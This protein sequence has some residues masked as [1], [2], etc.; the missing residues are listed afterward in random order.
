MPY[1]L[2][3]FTINSPTELEQRHQRSLL[4]WRTVVRQQKC[5]ESAR[6]AMPGKFATLLGLRQAL[7]VMPV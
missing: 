4:L 7:S 2:I 6:L 1:Q 5:L 3:Q